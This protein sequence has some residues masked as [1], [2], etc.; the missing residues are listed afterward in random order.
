MA[1]TPP[2]LPSQVGTNENLG[3]E[4]FF[5]NTLGFGSTPTPSPVSKFDR[6]LIKRETGE[7]A[8]IEPFMFMFKV[9]VKSTT[10][11]VPSSEL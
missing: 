4:A 8:G 5:I 7:G 11:Y 10:V 3:G 1:T 9:Y 2:P 6:R